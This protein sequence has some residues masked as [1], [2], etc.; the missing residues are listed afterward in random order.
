MRHKSPPSHIPITV[1][2][3]VL[4]HRTGREI[5]IKRLSIVISIDKEKALLSHG[6]EPNALEKFVNETVAALAGLKLE[7]LVI[8]ISRKEIN[9]DKYDFL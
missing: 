1:V 5:S 6:L 7:R 4:I 8:E 3:M 2:P 9:K